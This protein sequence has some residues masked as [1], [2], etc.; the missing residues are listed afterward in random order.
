MYCSTLRNNLLDSDTIWYDSSNMSRHVQTCHNIMI[1][2]D[3][4]LQTCP[5]LSWYDST[6][7]SR[8]VIILWYD[9]IRFYKHVQTC[10]DT[11]LQTCPDMSRLSILSRLVLDHKMTKYSKIWANMPKTSDVNGYDS[12]NLLIPRFSNI[13][14]LVQ[15][16]YDMNWYYSQACLN[17]FRIDMIRIDTILKH[18]KTRNENMTKYTKIE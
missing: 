3:T 18:V 15:N 9:L 4:I 14:K 2:F 6:N 7:L 10:L 8:L 12:R 17:L 13:S 5:D 11:I 1:R 16:L